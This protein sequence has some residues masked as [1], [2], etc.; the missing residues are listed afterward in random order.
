MIRIDHV[1]VAVRDLDVAAERMWR[2]FGLEALPGGPHDDAGT[3]MM[4]VP[5]DDDQFLEVI[6]ITDPQSSHPVVEWLRRSLAGGDRLLGLAIGVDDIAPHAARLSEPVFDLHRN[7]KDGKRVTFRLTGIV[8]MLSADTSP[9]FVETTGGREWRL[10]DRPA[11]HR[12]EPH[13]IRWVEFGGDAGA[14]ATRLGDRELP[15]RCRGG[16]PGVQA[17]CVASDAGDIVLRF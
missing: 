12:V 16:R 3:A 9:W 8:G 10:G 11:R 4:I 7:M 15:I 14:I 13:G 2:E 17:V 1:M 5:L 6:A